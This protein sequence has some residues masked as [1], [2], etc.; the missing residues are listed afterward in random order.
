MTNEQKRDRELTAD[1]LN[2]VTGGT[3]LALGHPAEPFHPPEPCFPTRPILPLP[4]F[5]VG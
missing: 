3:I 1:E 5:Q 4:V 2:L